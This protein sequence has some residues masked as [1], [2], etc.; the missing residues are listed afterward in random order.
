MFSPCFGY[1]STLNSVT[2]M[3]CHNYIQMIIKSTGQFSQYVVEESLLNINQK[4][5]YHIL[6]LKSNSR[7]IWSLDLRY[8][9]SSSLE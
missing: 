5:D 4:K 3:L 7:M 2:T 6:P 1:L 9:I 8:A